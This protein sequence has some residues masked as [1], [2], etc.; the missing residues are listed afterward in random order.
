[1]ADLTTLIENMGADQRE[2]ALKVLDY[3]TRPMT[4]RE[5]AAHL[6]H[7][8]VSQARAA[9]IAGAVKDLHIVAMIGDG[10]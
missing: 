7:H 9:K 5:I 1:M 3:L 10:K 4:G 2:G 6:R 8:G